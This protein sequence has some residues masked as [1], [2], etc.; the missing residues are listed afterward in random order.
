MTNL[1]KLLQIALGTGN[2]EAFPVLN[3]EQWEALKSAANKQTVLGIT[4][5]AIEKLPLE[6]QPPRQMKLQWIANAHKISKRN[7][8]LNKACK[9]LQKK[10][11]NVGLQSVILKGQGIAQLYPRPEHRTSGDIDVLVSMVP[12]QAG[13]E[14]VF[15]QS[16]EIDPTVKDIIGRLK[17]IGAGEVGKTVYHHIEWHFTDVEV[18]VHLRPMQFNNPW[19]NRRFQQW[20]KRFGLDEANIIPTPN[21]EFNMVFM[22]AHLYHHLLFEG[23]GLRQ[24]CDYAVLLLT[25]AKQWQS[26]EDK[27]AVLSRTRSLL[28]ELKMLRFTAGFM[29]IMQDVFNLPKEYLVIEPDESVGRFIQKEIEIAGNFGKYDER[30]DHERLSSVTGRFWERTKHRTRFLRLFPSEIF[31]DIPFR[32]W[33]ALWRLRNT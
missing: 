29:W 16:K 33:H 9:T 14:K 32:L 27:S 11:N 30:I 6:K 5:D 26:E 2:A 28:K 22:L 20:A 19:T 12:P 15:V 7:E 3:D 8:W 1:Y 31:W 24:V 10:L 23:V 25:A 17:S 13:N 18:E 4:W 21:V